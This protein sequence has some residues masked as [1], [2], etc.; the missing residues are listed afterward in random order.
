[1]T[2]LV[3]DAQGGGVGKQL[4]SALRSELPEARVLAVGTNTAATA[5]MLRAGAH[6]AATGENPAAVACRRADIIVGPIG[7]V[8]ADS[9]LG[10]VTPAMALSVAQSRARRVLIPFNHSDNII[11]GVSDRPSAELIRQAI[12]LVISMAR[13]P[14]PDLW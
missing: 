2:V 12:D 3:M 13:D 11:A 5:A 9:L 10:E 6:E 7:I 8:I 1:M 4:V 14:A